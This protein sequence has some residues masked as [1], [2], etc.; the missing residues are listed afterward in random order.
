[1]GYSTRYIR[2]WEHF[3]EE[4]LLRGRKDF[5][6][7]AGRIVTLIS[8]ESG[9]S[10]PLA[11]QSWFPMPG[12][13]WRIPLG[14]SGSTFGIPIAKEMVYRIGMPQVP[15]R[16]IWPKSYTDAGDYEESLVF[17]KTLILHG[18]R[19]SSASLMA[20]VYYRVLAKLVIDWWQ[21]PDFSHGFLVPIFA[22]YLV[23]AKRRTLLSTK[24]APT[25]SGIAVVALGL[26]VLLLGVYG[27]ELFLSRI[28]LVILLAG[29]V[30]SFGGWQL[31]K[32]LRF[33]LLVLL[34]A[35]P[36]P[37]ILFNEIT[38]PLQILASKL[39][40]ALLPLFGVPV[41]REGNV[42]ELS[43]MK[44][45]VAEAC[46]GIRSLMSLFTLAIFYGY[47]L[48]KSSLR[49][50]ILAVASIPIAIAANAVRI[51]GTG[52]CV[53]YWDPD[54]AMGFFHEFSG[55][56]IFLVSLGCLFI[57]HRAML[58]VSGPTEATMKSLRY[59]DGGCA[60][61]RNGA[62]A[63]R[64]RQFRSDSRERALVA[65]AA[66]NCRMV[67]KRSAD[68]PGNARCS[69]GRGLSC[70]AL[71]RKAD[72]RSR[73]ASLSRISQR[74]GLASPFIHRKTVCLVPAGHLNLHSTS[75]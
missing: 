11:R 44:L 31:L 34:L 40:S 54:K 56:V 36:I 6:L 30:L 33:P 1:M 13:S 12:N 2:P 18:V 68:R 61:G 20:A 14:L 47:F 52:L 19:H 16:R 41:L 49:R 65:D 3:Q 55:W 46:S 67:G 9:K 35:I 7:L 24:I 64:S 60:A 74:R 62:A 25:W 59:L 57:V 5:S 75:I 17:F 69:W 32:E 72:R 58:L 45:E 8:L 51:F 4:A 28:S 71:T 10:F 21:I 39:A 22:A 26:V 53:Q 66:R 50:T 48:E 29:L 23:W 38:F 42:I 15:L 63:V 37:A 73:S 43:A 27:A 70:R